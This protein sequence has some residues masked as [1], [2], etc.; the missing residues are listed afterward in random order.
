MSDSRG[1]AQD[2]IPPSCSPGM[3]TPPLESPRAAKGD[4]SRPRFL[5]V[6]VRSCSS[7]AGIKAR[8]TS[9]QRGLA[10]SLLALVKGPVMQWPNR[11]DWQ[12]STGRRRK[13]LTQGPSPLIMHGKLTALRTCKL[14][15]G[16]VLV[17]QSDGT[18]K[19][20]PDSSRVCRTCES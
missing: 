15:M 2:S 13:G 20:G 19:A 4:F 16:P 14:A 5:I 1:G 9:R 12:S 10:S 18:A 7:A 11:A 17:G 6:G 8:G 3:R